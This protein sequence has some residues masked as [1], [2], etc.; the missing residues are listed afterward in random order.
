MSIRIVLIEDH[1]LFRT[2][3]AQM[4]STENQFKIVGEAGTGLEGLDLVNKL[5]PDVVLL[6]IS[7][8]E[9]R[10]VEVAGRIKETHPQIK[11]LMVS[12]HNSVGYLR[13]A[14]KAGADGY[15]LKSTSVDEFF[16]ALNAVIEKKKYICSECAGH[17]V[18]PFAQD[19]VKVSDPLDGVTLR[20]KE[21]LTLIAEGNSNKEIAVKLSLSVK[22]VD[23][24][25][26]NL[27]RKLDLHNIRDIIFFAIE[28]KLIAKR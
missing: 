14:L 23:N 18:A 2:G 13:S 24:H 22:T 5:L 17:V 12:M 27:M 1:V 7:L 25:R 26:S 28:H 4:L 10:G 19:N 21:I 6:D 8:P 11:V 3:I 15:L 16:V 20:E 9:L